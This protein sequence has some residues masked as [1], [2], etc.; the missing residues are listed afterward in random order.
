MAQHTLAMY[1]L[2]PGRFALSLYELYISSASSI[3]FADRHRRAS[4]RRRALHPLHL[5]SPRERGT[6]LR[7]HAVLHYLV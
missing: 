7:P 6:R 3:A 2:R 1:R 4:I 5:G